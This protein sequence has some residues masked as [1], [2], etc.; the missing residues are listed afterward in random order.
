MID[1]LK[2]AVTRPGWI[3]VCVLVA[4]LLVDLGPWVPLK[5]LGTWILIVSL[6]GAFGFLAK[7]L[8]R[9]F[10]FDEKMDLSRWKRWF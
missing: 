10:L 9:P 7:D 1:F 6:S 2:A 8:F 5:T 4:V 3:I